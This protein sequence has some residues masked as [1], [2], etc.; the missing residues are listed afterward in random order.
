MCG[1]DTLL[2][3]RS[4]LNTSSQI[5]IKFS[6]AVPWFVSAWHEGNHLSWK[7]VLIIGYMLLMGQL[8]NPAAARTQDIL[9]GPQ[10]TPSS[11]PEGLNTIERLNFGAHFSP[12]DGAYTPETATFDLLLVVPIPP[13]FSMLKESS[14]CVKDRFGNCKQSNICNMVTVTADISRIQSPEYGKAENETCNYLA[15]LVDQVRSTRM[16]VSF[17]LLQE[18]SAQIG[19]MSDD[20]EADIPETR[21]K[22]S[23]PEN[24]SWLRGQYPNLNTR[25]NILNAVHGLNLRLFNLETAPIGQDSAARDRMTG[26]VRSAAQTLESL[27]N[28]TS[29]RE[30]LGPN[31]SSL[32]SNTTMHDMQIKLRKLTNMYEYNCISSDEHT[33]GDSNQHS[34]FLCTHM[35]ALLAKF[36]NISATMYNKY[37]SR[38]EE[39]SSI[40]EESDELGARQRRSA[41]K[42]DSSAAQ[43]ATLM[44]TTV[45]HT[46][47]R[48]TDLAGDMSSLMSSLEQEVAINATFAGKTR[49]RRGFFDGG[50]RLLRKL[51][52]V[53]TNTELNS[54]KSALTALEE[55]QFK[56]QKAMITYKGQTVA[57]V[58]ANNDHIKR[59]HGLMTL[60][61]DK[62][63]K[64]VTNLQGNIYANTRYITFATSMLTSLIQDLQDVARE[65][66]RFITGLRYLMRGKLSV[67]LVHE[68]TLTKALLNLQD[69]I[70]AKYPVF[71]IAEMNPAYYYQRS[72]PT[73]TW[74]NNTII[75]H[76]TVPLSSSDTMYK[77]YKLTTFSVPATMNANLTTSLQ[78][79]HDVFGV[80]YDNSRFLEMDHADLMACS[81]SKTIRCRQATKIHDTHSPTCALSLYTG[82]REQIR[83]LC[84][85]RLESS[86]Q[87]LGLTALSPGKL[88]VSNAEKIA[89]GCPGRRL[90]VRDGCTFCIISQACQCYITVTGLG[91]QSLSLPPV[92]H[93]C[94]KTS[95]SYDMQF[96]VNLAA[97]QRLADPAAIANL[98]ANTYLRQMLD[99]P[100]PE[101]RIAAY[102]KQL[103]LHA[104]YDFSMDLDKALSS[105]KRDEQLNPLNL[106]H[107][108]D[109]DDWEEKG[110]LAD[111]PI[112][113]TLL[114]ISG[115]TI[116][117]MVILITVKY[118][119]TRYL[120][121]KAAR[122]Y[123]IR[124]APSV[125]F[126]NK[127]DTITF[128]AHTSPSVIRKQMATQTPRKRKARSHSRSPVPAKRSRPSE[129]P[130]FN[131]L[132][133]PPFIST[134]VFTTPV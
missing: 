53:V 22:R 121:R 61:N 36:S 60:V 87:K 98:T 108:R 120:K 71:H 35:S 133:A 67:T 17:S 59:L 49:P 96:P 130:L 56:L 115:V 58:K 82:D 2:I 43:E 54:V 129:L 13:M 91:G 21:D 94:S 99:I 125:R 26:A 74:S 118:C 84:A 25:D 57:A 102:S 126:A 77:L 68:K 51:F 127:T 55:N 107:V 100:V 93:G 20:R 128:E 69:H 119:I 110:F 101:V 97:L 104:D 75:I 134:P 46:V 90:S 8:A 70:R 1:N 15:S 44:L 29:A 86:K 48:I 78:L 72:T 28:Q 111:Y 27:L 6:S 81:H 10:I 64:V 7:D 116:L 131:A 132:E 40:M 16:A 3:R 4:Q 106:A 5:R 62:F 103:D 24:I 30:L 80:S 34:Q 114:I 113:G 123:A 52:G 85:Y 23:P 122:T 31:F 9:L 89:M 66:D 79:L 12:I 95:W 19:V 88:L 83:K 11:L 50:G 39:M 65:M 117:I 32:D 38:L 124:Q 45:R 92:L 112:F 41:D 73:Y 109:L 14:K 76:I 37:M 105:V 63:D 42:T 33:A 47:S 18:L